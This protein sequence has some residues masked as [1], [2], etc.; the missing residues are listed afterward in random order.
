MHQLAYDLDF[1]D[2]PKIERDRHFSIQDGL[3]AWSCHESSDQST[4]E[5]KEKPIDRK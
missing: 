5:E 3:N 2:P 4:H 1:P